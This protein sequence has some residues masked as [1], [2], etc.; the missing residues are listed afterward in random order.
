MLNGLYV[1]LFVFVGFLI[2]IGFCFEWKFVM[3][4]IIIILFDVLVVVGYFLFSGC[5]FDLIVLVGLLL[6]MGFL[7]NDIIVVFDCVCEN[8]CSL[9]VELLEVMNC[10]IN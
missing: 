1:V 2:Y 6:V 4:V 3:V 7:I 8:F 10:L 5:E 9:C